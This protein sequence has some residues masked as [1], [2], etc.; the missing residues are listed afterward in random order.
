MI[1][2]RLQ[3]RG[4][5]SWEKGEIAFREGF[6]TIVGPKGVGKSS[7]ITAIEFTLFGDEAFRDY[8]GLMRE[9]AHSSD[10]VLEVEEQ[11]KRLVISRGLSRVGDTISQ[12]P[13]RL[14]LE[15][16]GTVHTLN[17]A[18][19]LNRDVKELLRIDNELL[20]YT[21]LAKQE[22]LKRLLSMDARSRKKIVD[23]L[24][25]FDAFETAWNELGEVIRDK[26][27]Y[28]RRLREEAAKYDL[29]SLSKSYGEI[30]KQIDNLKQRNRKVE[31][32]CKFEEEKLELVTLELKAFDQDAK[33]YYQ[34][35]KEIEEKRKRLADGM[36]KAEGFRGR[37][38][39][40]KQS[41]EEM[42]GEKKRLEGQVEGLWSNLMK[43]GYNG[44]RE[45]ASL[46][47]NVESLNETI[48]EALNAI[49]ID[50]K[51]IENEQNKEL[52]LLDGGSC[53]YCGQPLSSHKAKK[54]RQERLNHLENLRQRI[55]KNRVSLESSKQLSKMYASHSDDLSQLLYRVERLESQAQSTRHQVKDVQKELDAIQAVNNVIENQIKTA[56]YSLPTYDDALHA[57]KREEWMKQTAKVNDIKMELQRT[58]TNLQNLGTSLTDLSNKIREGKGTRE[59]AEQYGRIIED[60]QRIRGGCRAVLPT[61]RALYLKSIEHNI[62]K[63][64][65]DLNPASLFTI[66]VDED[67][68][69]T[70][71]VGNHTRSYR[72]LS[73]GERTEIALAYRIGMGNAIYEARTGTPM[74]LLILDEPTESLGNEE[75]DKAIERLATMLSNLK[76]R[77]IIVITHDQTF[78]QFADNTIQIRN[79]GN[80]SS[81]A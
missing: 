21:C 40:L 38:S 17:K 62:Q 29:E 25:G 13:E 61:L 28:F 60:L 59:K 23:S 9:D 48:L 24:L 67:Y 70:I 31:E 36:A 26:E 6:T 4:I 7:I 81:L 34:E 63:T 44:K 5:R 72:D 19:D 39:S 12:N 33:K 20:E 16:N 47:K 51:T 10:V 79:L 73:G 46:K 22:E 64:Y 75:E 77:Q 35:K 55:E 30:L 14:K 15:V 76:K 3:L 11:G 65:N 2:K 66:L 58:Q 68:T 50:E 45:L 71:S 80:R 27:G 32:R 56:E 18:G 42:E 8:N 1:L 74:N 78:T 43:V 49:G 41:L 37:I 69:P 53:P 52:A 57:E 54:F